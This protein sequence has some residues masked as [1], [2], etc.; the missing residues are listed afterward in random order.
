MYTK[1]L[2]TTRRN[3]LERCGG[4]RVPPIFHSEPASRERQS[5]SGYRLDSPQT[6]SK[7]ARDDNVILRHVQPPMGSGD[8]RGCAESAVM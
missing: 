5:V 2:S 3:S 7:N 6:F 4:A 8:I 1:L